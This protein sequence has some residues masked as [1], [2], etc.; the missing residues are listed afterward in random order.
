MRGSC[1]GDEQERLGAGGIARHEVAL[2]F[3]IGLDGAR[4]AGRGAI[5][6]RRS[7]GAAATATERSAAAAPPPELPLDGEGKAEPRPD[8]KLPALNDGMYRAGA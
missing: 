6:P 5:R 1:F 3:R 4:P 7:P 8:A 2:S